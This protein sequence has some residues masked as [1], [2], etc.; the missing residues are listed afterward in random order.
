MLP[1]LR[2]GRVALPV[3]RGGDDLP[4]VLTLDDARWV[5]T[6]ATVATL[7][8]DERFLG[9]LDADGDGRIRSDDVRRAIRWCLD[10]LR[11][12][13]SLD[14]LDTPLPLSELS[15]AAEGRRLAAAATHAMALAG[16]ALGEG[17]AD[18]AISLD[19]VARIRREE[20][21]RGLSAAGL[22]L[23]AAAGDD[24]GLAELI[25][26]VLAGT[27]GGSE[28]PSGERAVS[29]ADL[30]TFVAAAKARVAWW[31]AGQQ[32][33]VRPLG[34]ATPAAVAAVDAVAH[35]V[36]QLWFLCDA[37]ALDPALA[38][39]A[40]VDPAGADL[41]D[42]E[43]ARPILRRA[44]LAPPGS[45]AAIERSGTLN[46]LWRSAVEALFRDAVEPLLG[47]RD[48]LERSD[49]AALQ[50]HLA[51][52]RAWRAEET[53]GPMRDLPAARLRACLADEGSR[54]SLVGLL[55]AS[56]AAAARLAGVRDV[57][58]LL[59]YRR[60]LVRFCRS[61]VTMT[62]LYAHDARG[63]FERGTL[64]MDGRVFDLAV[65]VTDQARALT[66]GARSPM[67]ILYVDVMPSAGQVKE[68]VAV[69]VTAG[70][71]GYLVEGMWGVF[72]DVEGQEHH[73][74][75]DRVAASPISVREALLAPF[76]RLGELLQSAADKAA[77]SKT[78]AI[79][80]GLASAVDRGA[81]AGNDLTTPGVSPADPAAP[82][83]PP[84][85]AAPT[86]DSGPLSSQQLPWIMAGGGVAVAALGSTLTYA[87][88]TIWTAA[89]VLT[90]AFLGLPLVSALEGSAA[91][92]VQV[93]A[94]PVSIALV[95]LG[96]MLVPFL[97]YAIPVTIAT[98]LRLRRRD[99]AALLE[100]SGWAVNQRLLLSR[101][102]A[103]WYTRRP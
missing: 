63:L 94:V 77:S 27:G 23:P 86:P 60:D 29:R 34:D 12:P 41:L 36:E 3:V 65:R 20:E 64:I 16:D 66:F 84:S 88:H 6:G 79:D 97:V 101:D 28:H 93:A 99:L 67:Y 42:P 7:R 78:Q 58:R 91:V 19:L 33:S 50:D 40:R 82:S 21:A 47:P 30:D 32:P 39:G 2:V 4:H 13:S 25:A 90:S 98:W 11:A 8:G 1:S 61:F 89:G 87:A 24:E 76:R 85:P 51:A 54:A 45:D 14:P 59:L 103:R 73:A 100:G 81:K 37:I 10:V 38:A 18:G 49:W 62:D 69:P 9:A 80:E 55:D 17:E 74:R 72:V 52:N 44:P 43:A 102:Q 75:V 5:A 35:K 95:L 48:R 26:A 96:L 31:D 57:E 15:D 83:A 53:T 22:V 46:P 92:A 68:Q 70:E 71:A 56:D